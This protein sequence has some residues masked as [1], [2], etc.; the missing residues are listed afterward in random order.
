M[1][2]LSAD[3]MR[4]SRELVRSERTNSKQRRTDPRILIALRVMEEGLFKPLTVRQLSSQVGLSSSRFVHLFTAEMGASFRT[5]LQELRLR[6]AQQLLRDC[7]L[8]VKEVCYRVGYSHA[9]NFT[10]CFKQRFGK[11]PSQYKRDALAIQVAKHPVSGA[12]K[13]QS[14]DRLDG[15]H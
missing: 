13:G 6:Q 2:I 8:S 3:P 7:A 11:T 4:T 10:R 12:T 15:K 5:H 14:A 1:R 9:P